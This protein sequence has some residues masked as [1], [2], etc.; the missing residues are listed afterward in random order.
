MGSC[1]NVHW[2]NGGV[3]RKKVGHIQYF[4]QGNNKDIN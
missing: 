4:R 3:W 2:Q 1:V